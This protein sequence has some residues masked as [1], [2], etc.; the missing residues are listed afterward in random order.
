MKYSCVTLKPVKTEEEQ[1][2]VIAWLGDI[3]FDMFELID[4]EL[5]AYIIQPNFEQEQWD[6][7]IRKIQH[8]IPDIHHDINI[9]PTVNYNELWEKSFEPVNIQNQVYIHA[10]FQETNHKIPYCICITPKMAF[11]TGHHQTTSL[12]VEKMLQLPL[13]GASVLDMGCGTAVLAILSSMKGASRV[14]AID[15][16]DQAIE[17]AIENVAVNKVQSVE[18][19]CGDIEL[20]QHQVFDIILA[21]INRNILLSHMKSYANTLA[22]DG[23]LLISGFYISD[24][25]ALKQEA[26]NHQLRFIDH[27]IKD[28]WTVAH[29]QKN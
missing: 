9:V 11:G 10:D 12:M 27:A 19:S 21:N 26:Q 4:G 1:D 14:L 7:A 16:D 13:K 15:I 22:K 2:V 6:E 8:F 20:I 3:G 25:N 17:N 18:L 5:K 29:F 24:L 28:E 23:V